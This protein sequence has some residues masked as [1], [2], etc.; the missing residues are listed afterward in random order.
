[1]PHSKEAATGVGY[2]P[3]PMKIKNLAFLLFSAAMPIALFASPAT[4]RKI[5]DAAQS[6]YN[7]RVVLDNHV[8]AKAKDGIVTLTGK[9]E[10]KDAKALASDTVE[11]L[12]GVKS[13]RN[14]LTLASSYPEKSDG[15]M[16]LKI[17]GRLLVKGDVS[18]TATS[19]DVKDGIA[20]LTGTSD[21][22]AQKEL[23][24]VYAAEIDGV[25]SVQNNLVVDTNKPA[26]DKKVAETIDDASITTQVKRALAGHKSTSALA[27]K[28]TTNEG[29]VT[30][31][32]I[33]ASDAEKSLVTK[34]A[35]DVRGTKSV[36]NK[37]TVK[38]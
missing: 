17:R 32:G 1:M 14:E 36:S 26:M 11:N 2:V 6:S 7:Y 27:T 19:V 21:N 33:A 34:L 35:K 23:T 25:K 15:W 38:S 13:V 18:A 3:K 12:P 24:G 37:M 20:T 22:A 9:V 16:A 10:D 28:V 31:T 29:L 8:T 4:D 5:E 30:I